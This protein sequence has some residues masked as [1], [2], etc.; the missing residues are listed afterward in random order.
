MTSILITGAT[1]SVGKLLVKALGYSGHNVVILKREK[2][3]ISHLM[4]LP[5]VEFYDIEK[6]IDLNSI[7]EIHQN[8]SCIIHLATLYY[9]KSVDLL[10]LHD[11]NTTFGLKLLKKA[12]AYKISTFIN[13][14]TTLF[15]NLNP[16]TISKKYFSK[17]GE[18]MANHGQ[19]R[20][21]NM[22]LH[23][24]YGVSS[25]YSK[26]T[27]LVIKQCLNNVDEIKLTKGDQI[28]DF[29]HIEDVISCLKHVLCF[30]ERLN[31]GYH[32]IQIGT[33]RHITLKEFITKIHFKTNSKTRLLF[34]SIPY[35]KNEPMKINLTDSKMK[36]LGWTS[37]IN[38][39]VGIN[40][41][42][43]DVKINLA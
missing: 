24:M 39:D 26:F 1:G 34:G 21:I 27:T 19:I 12:V 2:S 38:L 33:G 17:I 30:V 37:K 16:Y 20:F 4:E 42:I 41:A 31:T 14:D 35:R 36:D 13:I 43:D 3:K 7:F 25:D 29:I 15:E 9:L 28:R 11:S 6:D 23:L 10:D 5:G 22:P 40:K 8:I 32:D 18:F